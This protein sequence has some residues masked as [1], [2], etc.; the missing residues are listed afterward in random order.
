VHAQ[1][2][3]ADAARAFVRALAAPAAAAAL[4]KSGM[5]PM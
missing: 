4:R 1:S 5:K 2:A 3:Q